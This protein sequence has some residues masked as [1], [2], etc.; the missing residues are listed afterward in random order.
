MESPLQSF[1][2]VLRQWRRSA[3]KQRAG[4]GILCLQVPMHSEPRS[5]T[6]P[7]TKKRARAA[8]LLVTILG[9]AQ[10]PLAQDSLHLVMRI[11]GESNTKRITNV[12][13]VRYLNGDG[14]KDALICE[15]C[16]DN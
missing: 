2:V 6:P 4:V 7:I 11:T 5:H 13:G 3:E 8:V 10:V 9:V 1:C 15:P 16:T 14:Y 12:V